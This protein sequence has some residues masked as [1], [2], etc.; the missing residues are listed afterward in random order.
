M[1]DTL[2][3]RHGNTACSHCSV[4]WSRYAPAVAALS[5]RFEYACASVRAE[6]V[7]QDAMRR[8][9]ALYAWRER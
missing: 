4:D 1:T 8:I 6:A 3:C 9:A 5:D 7:T 2:R